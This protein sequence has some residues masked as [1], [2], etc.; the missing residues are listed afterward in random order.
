MEEEE[1]EEEKEEEEEVDPKR[2]LH[3]SILKTRVSYWASCQ[4]TPS[5]FLIIT[6]V[7]HYRKLS[8]INT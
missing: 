7:I 4:V 2:A 5:I 1:E 8:K 6:N 3:Q